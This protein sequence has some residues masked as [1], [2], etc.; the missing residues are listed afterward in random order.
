MVEWRDP[1]PGKGPIYS[2]WVDEL[3]AHPKRWAV[4]ATIRSQ[5]TAAHRAKQ[6]KSSAIDG[7]EGYEFQATI[8]QNGDSYDVYARYMG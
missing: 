2:D 8:R 7:L 4:V 3:L 6:I 5:S 1:P